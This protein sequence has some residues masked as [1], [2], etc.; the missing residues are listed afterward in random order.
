M[1]PFIQ[2]TKPLRSSDLD[3]E[4]LVLTRADVTPSHRNDLSWSGAAASFTPALTHFRPFTAYSQLPNFGH[5]FIPRRRPL[6]CKF[7][8]LDWGNRGRRAKRK[9][10]A[11]YRPR[12][13]QTKA[14]KTI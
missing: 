2:C 13:V 6:R 3:Y 1:S 14:A 9:I 11:R 10:N 4:W 7:I 8:V 5:S 12:K